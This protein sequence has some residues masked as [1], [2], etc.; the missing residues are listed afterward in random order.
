[1][2][3]AALPTAGRVVAPLGVGRHAD[4]LIT[5]RAAELCFGAALWYY[6]DFPYVREA[7]ALTAV[8]PLHTNQWRLTGE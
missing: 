5:R 1:A 6:E 2:Q 7:G 4:H 8:I 3:M